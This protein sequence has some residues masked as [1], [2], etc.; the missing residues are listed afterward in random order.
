MERNRTGE[1]A[2][3]AALGFAAGAL[4]APPARKLAIQGTEALIS[5]D[6]VD[7]LVKEHR[8]VQAKME[9]LLQTSER[10]V[11]KRK[12]LLAAIDLALT[13]HSLQEEKV[14]YPALRRVDEAQAQHLFADHAEVKSLI[15]ELTYDIEPSSPTW[16]ARAQDLHRAL[17][18]H[19]RE[20]E[21]DIFPMFRNRMSDEQNTQLSRHMLMQGALV[22]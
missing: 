4:L 7:A 18:E 3:T 8:L 6:W 5:R 20:E 16:L 17:E 2:L 12:T 1:I 22:V 14:I 10:D 11:G 15:A 9:M 21:E 13:K 19:M